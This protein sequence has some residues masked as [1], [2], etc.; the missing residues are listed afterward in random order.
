M[1]NDTLDFAE[2][3]SRLKAIAAGLSIYYFEPAV[4]WPQVFL[5]DRHGTCQGPHICDVCRVREAFRKRRVFDDP[6]QS[7]GELC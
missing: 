5:H 1:T 6:G 3:I 4:P 7:G 2:P